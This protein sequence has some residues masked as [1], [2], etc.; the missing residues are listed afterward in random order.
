MLTIDQT[1]MFELRHV[2]KAYGANQALKD[3][4]LRIYPGEV[5]A[6]MGGN[7]AG[8]STLIKIISGAHQAD[9][10]EVLLDGVQ[11][12]FKT[13]KEAMNK[14]I[15]VVYQELSLLPHLTVSENIALPS[16]EVVKN[17]VYNW[18]KSDELAWEA[19]AK[20]GSAT[21]SIKPRDLVSDL[22]PDQ[23]QMVEIARAV[24]QNAR[25]ILLDEPTSSL[26]FEETEKFF[27][28]VRTLCKQGIGLIFVSHRMNEV[29]ELSD[30]ITVLRDG[31]VVIDGVPMSQKSDDEI[32]SDM[33]GEKLNAQAKKEHVT[34]AFK[35]AKEVLSM[36]FEGME[37]EYTVHEGE[38]V[39]LAG[40][41]GSG[42]SSIL[43]TIWGIRPNK[44][45]KL[46][47]FG[48]SYQPQSPIKALRKK[49]AYISEDRSE[50][51]L[52]FGLSI[53]E[54]VLLPH[55]NLTRKALVKD[56]AEEKLH[57]EIIDNVQIKVPDL[58]C[59]PGALS[60]GNQQ[61][62]LFGRWIADEAKL[63]LLDEPTRGVDIRTKHEIYQRVRSMVM[64]NNA[65]ALVVSSE[66]E[67]L[68]QLCDK[69]LIVRE[70]QVEEVLYGAD[71]TEN[72]MMSKITASGKTIRKTED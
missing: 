28:S 30:R 44:G 26:N 45:I 59:T 6:L 70:G 8:K 11:V 71:I 31:A 22:R 1:P 51:G 46:R 52:F 29:R 36:S 60:G 10:G 65:G 40:L 18:K 13:P 19:L 3:G 67:E 66:L 72:N 43:R 50:S 21:E 63:F 14:G 56:R 53:R 68:V 64:A 49:I 61:K 4:S 20:L 25:I 39:G 9:G 32:I 55:R 12:N 24:G 69:V 7:G 2:K 42:R 27:N 62:L 54:T 5:H 34:G 33:L 41:A 58:D 17:G 57:S 23:M 16:N 35:D 47:Y 48:Q 38:I 37:E 15:Q